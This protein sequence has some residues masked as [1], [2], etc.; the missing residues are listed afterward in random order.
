MLNNGYLGVCIFCNATIK[1]VFP[2]NLI[3]NIDCP[4]CGK[5]R[6]DFRFQKI[7][8]D[9]INKYLISGYLQELNETGKEI[10][11]ITLDN[12]KQILESA[13]IPKTTNARIIRLLFHIFRETSELGFQLLFNLNTSPSIGYAKNNQE[14]RFML[15]AL[16]QIDYINIDRVVDNDS[17]YY[18]LSP[19]GFTYC[20][21]E[22]KKR[23][24][25]VSIFVAR[26]FSS[27]MDTVMKDA[28]RPA[29]QECGFEAFS[30]GDEPFNGDIT[31]KIIAGIKEC[32]FMIAD[33][34]GHR[35][36]VYFEAGY[37]EG[38]G[39]PVIY[40][41][42]DDQKNEVHFD[43]NHNNF[44]FWNT[45]EIL[46]EKLIDRIRATIL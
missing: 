45:P 37:A 19:K 32:R 6:T 10:P 38:L 8:A 33:F 31:D 13:L 24:K 40:T 20:E 17:F 5:Y 11:I 9:I 42:R 15:L 26:W 41:C 23:N 44:I 12:F 30:V 18:H 28:I 29:A 1:T 21:E 36:G 22:Y 39:L 2:D 3:Y 35:G 7:N 14:L 43:I 4:N 25:S 27:E 34:T 46:K 16:E